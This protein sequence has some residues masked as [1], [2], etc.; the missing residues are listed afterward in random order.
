MTLGGDQPLMN[1]PRS[2]C[3]TA[4]NSK[5]PAAKQSGAVFQL[6]LQLLTASGPQLTSV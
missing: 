3:C 1:Q 6:R 4:F 5:A 2:A